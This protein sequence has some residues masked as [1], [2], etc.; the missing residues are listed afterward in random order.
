MD[1]T[2]LIKVIEDGTTTYLIYKTETKAWFI[3][4]I[5]EVGDETLY[6]VADTKSNPNKTFQNALT[7]PETF[8][9]NDI[10]ES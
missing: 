6:H 10:Y 3:K 9:Y 1:R 8:I 7:N 4:R 2:E 5:Q